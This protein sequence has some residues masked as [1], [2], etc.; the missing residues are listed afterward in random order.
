MYTLKNI[1]SLNDIDGSMKNIH[2]N[3]QVYKRFF[4]AENI[5]QI[6]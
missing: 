2:E 6:I 3:F 4:I 5:L 1:G